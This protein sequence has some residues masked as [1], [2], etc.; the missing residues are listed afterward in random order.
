MEKEVT[1]MAENLRTTKYNDGTVIP[2]VTN[3]GTWVSISTPAYCWYN[4]NMIA[5]GPTYGALYNWYTVNTDKLCP[6]G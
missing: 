5:Y 3:S 4:N 1:W 2:L 6:T